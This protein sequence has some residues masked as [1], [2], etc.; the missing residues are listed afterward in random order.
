MDS[1]SPR[2]REIVDRL[3]ASTLI[4]ASDRAYLEEAKD[5]LAAPSTVTIRHDPHTVPAPT[6]TTLRMPGGER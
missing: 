4:S 3:L 1:A 2:L 5:V 6:I